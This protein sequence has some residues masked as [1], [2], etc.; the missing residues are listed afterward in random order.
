MDTHR[1]FATCLFLCIWLIARPGF[2]ADAEVSE[3]LPWRAGQMLTEQWSV[4]EVVRHPEFIRLLLTSGN[5]ETSVEIAVKV[6]GDEWATRHHRVQPGPGADPPEDLLHTVLVQL[7]AWEA[8]HPGSSLVRV[9]RDALP[10]D[11]DDSFLATLRHLLASPV[12]FG[13][14]VL[15][16][17][18]AYAIFPLLLLFWLAA[19]FV[20]LRRPIFWVLTL[21][22]V[23]LLLLI[24]LSLTLRIAEMNQ[25][26]ADDLVEA[27]E[28]HLQSKQGQPMTFVTREG[29]DGLLNPYGLYDNSEDVFVPFDPKPGERNFFVFGGS[30]VLEAGQGLTFTE[31]LETLLSREWNCDARGYNLGMKGYDSFSVR[32][33]LEAAIN[34]HR[35]DAVILYSG[36]NDYINQYFYLKT[37]FAVVSQSALLNALLSFY[38]GAFYRP[39]H[40]LT[41]AS[42]IED[43]NRFREYLVEPH[44]TRWLFEK[45]LVQ[46]GNDWFERINKVILRHFRANVD[47]MVQLCQERDIPLLVV[48]PIAN[49]TTPP[50]GLDHRA[51]KAYRAGMAE[52]DY[53][54]RLQLLIEARD[55]DAFGFII[56][57]KSPLVDY[58]RSLEKREG[59][60]LLDLQAR[61]E[62]ERMDF[63]EEDF[64]SPLYLNQRTHAR[65]AAML[66]EMLHEKGFCV[67]PGNA[68]PGK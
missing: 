7:A 15:L 1:I 43:F 26:T 35:P 53:P 64:I 41:G 51:R 3:A 63:G 29:I 58:L 18:I 22:P 57:V 13:L 19:H 33:R 17:F 11:P 25:L 50:S 46:P 56:R 27:M 68:E 62:A 14:L 32:S 48:T 5:S 30:S 23:V 8:R 54:T 31:Q 37:W 24:L 39:L 52:T 38:H 55:L 6:S 10:P 49:L 65:L 28:G 34:R 36:H 59:V 21:T 44:L 42:H 60:W 2:A 45:G 16:L 61:L 66:A 67:S 47:R 12:G 9:F 20:F 40:S 4:R